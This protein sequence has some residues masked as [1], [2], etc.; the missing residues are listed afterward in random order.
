M[1]FLDTDTYT[2]SRYGHAKV[3]ERLDAANED[4]GITIVTRIEVLQ[5][6]FASV[7]KASTARE[8]MLSQERLRQ[9]DEELEGMLI[10]PITN[11]AAARFERLRQE[12]ALR[13]I[14]LADLAIGCIVLENGGRLATRNVK[15]FRLIPGLKLE[16]WA[17]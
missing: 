14:G 12:K 9:T 16:N 17:D 11:A 2:L 1:I 4:V 8:L 15:D 3:V 7:L 13:K 10:V 6:R 5:G